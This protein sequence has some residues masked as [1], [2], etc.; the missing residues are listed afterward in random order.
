M[1]PATKSDT[2]NVY[3]IPFIPNIDVNRKTKG[4]NNI[5]CLDI[6]TKKALNGYPIAWY[7]LDKII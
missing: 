1:K 7:T 3:H 6:A 4:I 2:I 5:N